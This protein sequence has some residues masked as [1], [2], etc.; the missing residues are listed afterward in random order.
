MKADALKE[1]V[2]KILNEAPKSRKLLV[3]NYS[4]FMDV[5]DYCRNNYLQSGGGASEALEETKTLTA[6]SLASI[7]YQIS[8]LATSVLSL[9]D[10]QTDQL[11]HMESSVNLIGQT[12]AMHR[13][14][15]SRREIGV[16]TVAQ[17]VPCGPKIL[18]AP[19]QP[20]PPYSRRPISYQQLDGLGHGVKPTGKEPE[21]AGSVR[22]PASSTRSSGKAAA[23]GLRGAAAPSGGSSTFR[24]AVAPPTIPLQRDAPD[25]RPPSPADYAVTPPET[26]PSALFLSVTPP[27]SLET[28]P[29]ESSLP[30]PSPPPPDPD[31]DH[32]FPVP[33][34]EE[35][36]LPPPPPAILEV[37]AALPPRKSDPP[38]R[39]VSLRVRSGPASRRRR[40]AR[41][42]FLPAVQSL[43]IPPPPPYPPP[44]APPRPSSAHRLRLPARLEHL[45]LELPSLPPLP[46]PLD[47]RPASDD[48]PA[49]EE[50]RGAPP[51][52]LEK[53]VA[54][55]RYEAA[56]PGDLSLAEGDVI[57]LT[58]RHDDGW[59]EGVLRGRRGFFPDN[60]VRSCG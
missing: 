36:E 38:G 5:A 20:R 15:V 30:P 42:L 12:V 27:P 58:H 39:C 50:L 53:V 54:L 21:G 37:D 3:E 14:K 19:A 8:T 10:A 32:S 41:S 40:H 18:R 24:K 59:S 25:E 16:F 11:R 13:E 23:E 57:Y 1:E 9:L 48:A 49:A 51:H 31:P 60:Y 7:A 29:E 43:L 46:S 28:V 52:Y 55:Y 44:S 35:P 45:D 2:A 34:N 6:Q 56:E 26:R 17:R 4:N 22:M 33:S 47:S